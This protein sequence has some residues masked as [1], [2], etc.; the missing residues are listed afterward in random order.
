MSKLPVVEKRYVVAFA[1]TATLFFS[2]GLASQFNDLLLHHFQKALDLTRTRASFTQFAFYIGYFCAPLPAA[3]IIRRLG[4]K[5]CMVIGLAMYAGGAFLFVPAAHLRIYGIFLVALYIIAFGA[6]FLET[7]ANPYIA[8]MGEPATSSPRLNFAQAFNGVA[9]VLGPLV[10]GYVIFSGVEY[11]PAQ[12]ATMTPQAIDAWRA[13]EAAAVGP[14][15]LVLAILMVVIA[16]AIALTKYPALRAEVTPEGAG[17]PFAV[18]RRP[19]VLY[20]VVAQFFYVGAQV[21]TWSLL[22][23]FSQE[24]AHVP[25]RTGAQVYLEATMIAFCV[26]RFFGAWLQRYIDPARQLM[27]YCGCNVILCSLA[28]TLGGFPS[29]YAMVATSFFMSIMFPTIFALGLEKLGHET[30]F[31]SSFIVMAIS[32]A[33]VVPPLMAWVS[34]LTGALHWS[35]LFPA[36][37]Y[38][39]VLSFAWMAPKMGHVEA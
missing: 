9:T 34:D 33:A 25:E 24:A 8:I 15:Y 3:M 19:R 22:V 14:P 31:A 7:S 23:D 2:W 27:L 10:G 16:S 5:R 26:G 21:G 13:S 37:C 4:Y 17:S 32:G 18:L 30:E 28:A 20:A 12:L 39:V 1:L 11:T 38:L 35:L 29:I 36:L 6:A